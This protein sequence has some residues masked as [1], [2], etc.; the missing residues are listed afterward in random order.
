MQE[1]TKEIGSRVMELRELSE[2]NPEEMADYL[3]IPV[4]TY[5]KYESGEEDIPASI[6]YEISHKFKVDMGLLLTGEE[7]RM[8][9]FSVTRKEKGVAVERRKQYKYENLSERFI[10]KKSEP[11]IVTVEPREDGKKPSTNSHPGQE[12][13]YVLEGRMKIYIHHH[14][15]VL[16]EGDSIFFDSNYKHAMEALDNKPAKFLAIVM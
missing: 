11:F 6:L 13:N 7:T 9:I 5:Y 2:I 3:K 15:I 10:H 14:E 16:N 4:D 12:F 1:K 8:H